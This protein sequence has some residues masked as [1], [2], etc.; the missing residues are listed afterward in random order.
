[1]NLQ[2][3]IAALV[4]SLLLAPFYAIGAAAE[5]AAP[6]VDVARGLEADIP[7]GFTVAAVGDIQMSH[8]VRGDP[9]FGRVTG[10]IS[11]ADIAVGNFE[12]NLIDIRHFEGHPEPTTD[13]LRPV[14]DPALAQALSDAGFDLLG[15][16]NN[17][18]VDWGHVGMRDTGDALDAARLVHA[19]TGESLAAARAARYLAAPAGRI[20]LVAFTTTYEAATPAL[21]PLGE[22]PGRPGA[23]TLPVRRIILVD[24]ETM[25]ALRR[26]HAA[27]PAGSAQSDPRQDRLFLFGTVYQESDRFGLAYEL[28]QAALDEIVRSVRQGKLN[29]DFLI[30]SV[31]SHEPGNWSET[32]ADFLP[33]VAHAMIE[34]G[35][36][37]VVGHGPHRLRGI[38]I[39]RGKPIFYSLGNF[40]FQIAPNEPVAADLYQRLG[41]DPQ[42]MTAAELLQSRIGPHVQF[43]PLYESVVPV[44]TFRAGRAARIELHPIALSLDARMADRGVPRPAQG[45]QARR[46]LEH[47]ARLSRPFGTEIRI[48]GG[49]GVINGPRE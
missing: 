15:R 13:S 4:I 43:D 12:S 25:R 11:S 19:G 17:H 21:P 1:M 32:P 20:G 23:S 41:G 39:Y 10:W 5:P 28:D 18:A 35:A 42:A 2:P 46:I 9:G 16:A 40:A 7:D 45:E 30:V 33:A 47:L 6:A 3:P 36:D 49:L 24:A 26:L 22:A 34:A 27:Q 14:S 44:T 8:P 31:H 48:S 38:E 37:M 29:A